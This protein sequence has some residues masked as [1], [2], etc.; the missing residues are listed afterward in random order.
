MKKRS[1]T[2]YVKDKFDNLIW[3]E[4]ETFCED[5]DADDLSLKLYNIVA[6]G[7][8][9]I[10]D[11]RVN[12]V[13]VDDKPGTLISFDI[14]CEVDF[15]VYDNDVYH[16]DK[17]EIS[18]TW[19]KISCDGDLKNNLDSLEVTEVD[20]YSN[21]KHCSAPMSDSLVKKVI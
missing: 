7:E 14:I 20:L 3:R 6:P 13:N 16:N 4:I 12:Y 2:E 5:K 18:S 17:E 21:K 9:E 1:F 15:T 10:N 8:I 19:F 11:I